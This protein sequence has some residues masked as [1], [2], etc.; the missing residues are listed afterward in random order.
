[1]TTRE[2][3]A[4]RLIR[5]KAILDLLTKAN[6]ETRA[7]AKLLYRP[8]SAD[9]TA[10]G[11]VSMAKGRTAARVT[12]RG[13]LTAWLKAHNIDGA[14]IVTET[15]NP[16][17]VAALCASKGEMIDPATGEVCQVPGI[18]VT[19]ADPYLTVTT[20]PE[21]KEWALGVLLLGRGRPAAVRNA[22]AVGDGGRRSWLSGFSRTASVSSA[23]R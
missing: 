9:A 14:I 21:G 15:I 13:A 3:L 2:T 8:G 23:R 5:Q 16:A 11:R 22:R 18:E 6:D 20:T 12:D 7:E 1:M 10:A 19:T 17:L 4:D